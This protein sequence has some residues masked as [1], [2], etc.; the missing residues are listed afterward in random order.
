MVGMRDV[1]KKA[2]VSLSTVS[3]VVNGT[4]YV[5]QEMRDR[6]EAAMRELDYIPNELARNLFSGRT[7]LVGVIVPTIRHPFFSTMTAEL[8]RALAERGLRTMLCSTVD[9][10]TGEAEYVDMLRRHMMDGIVMGAH[11]SHAPDYWTSINRPVVAFDRYLGEGIPS[12]GADHE[13]GGRLAAAMLVRSG[14]RRVVAVGGPRAQFHAFVDWAQSR[15]G[16]AGGHT[17]GKDTTFP[18]VRYHLTLERELRA[19][20]VGYEYVEA[21]EVYDFRGYAETIRRV[22]ERAAAGEVDAVV[23]SDLGAAF[24]V[25]EALRLGIRVPDELQIVAYDGTYLTSAA[26][27]TIT[28][29][30]QDCRAMAELVATRMSDAIRSEAG[31]VHGAGQGADTGEAGSGFVADRAGD[32][33]DDVGVRAILQVMDLFDDVVPVTVVPGATTRC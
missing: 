18:T 30:R 23:S 10:R 3:L 2:G 9:M 33:A 16:A 11:T 15:R 20:G 32:D 31:G 28:A 24:C 21:G 12:V 29:I 27:M 4:G 22:C 25:H 6:V 5:S 19:A 1:A 13:Q 14:A 7:S 17:V 8:Q 26:G